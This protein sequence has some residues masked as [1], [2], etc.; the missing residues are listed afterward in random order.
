MNLPPFSQYSPPLLSVGSGVSIQSQILKRE[1]E[2][3][4]VP[5]GISMNVIVK[6]VQHVKIIWAFCLWKLF[7]CF[8]DRKNRWFVVC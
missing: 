1:L 6:H 8:G 2:K 3:K 5:E 4:R 7:Q